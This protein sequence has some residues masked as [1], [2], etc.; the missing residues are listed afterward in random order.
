[1]SKKWDRIV[2]FWLLPGAAFAQS[3]TVDRALINQ[4]CVTC[5]NDRAKT[6]GLTLQAPS[7]DAETGEKIVRKVSTGMM[8]PAGAR[9][10]DRAVLEQFASGL[11]ASLDRVAAEHPNPGVT[12]LH[13]LNRTEYANA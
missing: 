13:R 11:E 7:I 6:G 5:H 9:R 8:P 1:M 3:I 10:P 12:A 2:F 4:Y